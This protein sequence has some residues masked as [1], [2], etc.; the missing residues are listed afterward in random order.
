MTQIE[1]INLYYSFDLI[2]F[3]CGLDLDYLIFS[4]MFQ[5][6]QDNLPMQEENF[7]CPI[8]FFFSYFKQECFRINHKCHETSHIILI[9]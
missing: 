1:N 9:T 8:G 7:A 6:F 2:R 4:E 3:S 5:M